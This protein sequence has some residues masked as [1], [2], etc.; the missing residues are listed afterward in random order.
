[1]TTIDEGARPAIESDITIITELASQAI[2]ELMPQRGGEVWSRLEAR[3]EPI[4]SGLRRDL[5]AADSSVVVGTIDRVVVG[6]GTI[7]LDAAARRL[8]SGQDRRPLRNTR[9]TRRRCRGSN[10]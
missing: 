6:Y 7:R 5:N 3:T 10:D 9:S 8:R 1:M 2:S 4:E